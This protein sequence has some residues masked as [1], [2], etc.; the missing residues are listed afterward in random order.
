MRI[1]ITVLAMFGSA[2]TCI[3]GGSKR[4]Y[5]ECVHFCSVLWNLHLFSTA[6]AAERNDT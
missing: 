6:D 1:H 5:K 2:V 3:R 4:Q